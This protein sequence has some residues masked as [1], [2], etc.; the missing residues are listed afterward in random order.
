MGE[1]IY[2]FQFEKEIAQAE[3]AIRQVENLYDS[4]ELKPS[5]LAKYKKLVL[6]LKKYTAENEADIYDWN[7][8]SD[9]ETTLSYDRYNRFFLLESRI[10]EL[11]AVL[12][13]AEDDPSKAKE[14]IF[15][16][17]EKLPDGD[18]FWL[19][20][21]LGRT[22]ANVSDR[23]MQEWE[24]VKSFMSYA[25]GI[26]LVLLFIWFVFGYEGDDTFEEPDYCDTNICR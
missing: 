8:E 10:L 15:L 5:Y 22:Y 16:S 21:G 6:N 4:G 20:S 19:A 3:A 18:K 12:A 7:R 26:A 23:G 2:K 9:R 11:K 25:L 17:K 1:P 24:K 14:Y 13:Y